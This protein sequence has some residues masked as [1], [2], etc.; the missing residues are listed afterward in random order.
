M[1]KRVL[2]GIIISLLAASGGAYAYDFWG[3]HV[4]TA[5]Y[6]GAT[7]LTFDGAGTSGTQ[8]VV[9]GWKYTR[10]DSTWE[11]PFAAPI[12]GEGWLASRRSDAQGLFF[13]PDADAAR[14]VVITTSSQ[15]GQGA[16]ELGYD[17]RLFSI[18]DL[19]IDTAAGTYG[20]GMRISD[21][22]WAED[23]TATQP[24]Y[25]IY[26]ASGGTGN[27]DARDAGTLG[28]VA[29]NPTWARVGNQ[30]LPIGS[31]HAS[32]FFIKGTG[33]EV[34]S[35]SVSFADTGIAYNG[36]RVFAYEV[37]VPW[38]T[39]GLDPSNNSFTAS[40]RP[41]CGNDLIT[42][43][44]SSVMTTASVPEPSTIITLAGG[45]LGLLAGRKR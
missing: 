3:I 24:Q 40:W 8:Y 19:K 22:L 21:L 32:A 38:T 23:P 39:L 43:D 18:G 14:L 27:I 30:N 35:A 1:I 26:L 42:G 12:P 17:K 31:D 11:G 20:V 33:S 2:V 4:G 34:G 29:L 37:A 13:K 5:S 36:A 10:V 7:Q 45:L 15:N 44:F 6:G 41:D 28:T 16:P 9:G 25:Q